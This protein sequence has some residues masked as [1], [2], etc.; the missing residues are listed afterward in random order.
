MP[1]IG[2]ITPV[3]ATDSHY[4]ATLVDSLLAQ[5]LGDWQLIISEDG[6]TE[7]ARGW[8]ET[9]PRIVWLNSAARNG[10]AAARNL[11]ATRLEADVWRNLDADDWLADDGVLERTFGAF[12]RE[13]I[14]YVVGPV[15]DVL[16][17]VETPFADPFAP[18]P[19]EPGVLYRGW[20]DN[21]HRGL[22]HPTSLA[23][24][25]DVFRRYGGYPAMRSSEDTAL[26]LLV[27][28]HERGWYLDRPVTFYRKRLGSITTTA[29]HTDPV[30]TASRLAFIR[31][32]CETDPALPAP[33][34]G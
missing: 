24:R 4:L 34:A 26:L 22:V 18:G 30:E 6:P 3:V 10:P 12:A 2:V 11:A 1:R 9:D 29:G 8:A 17:G 14:A 21:A 32:V 20:L 31:H 23:M 7:S 15:V 5:T 27:S 25:T 33:T 13:C 16:D 19:I 28:Q